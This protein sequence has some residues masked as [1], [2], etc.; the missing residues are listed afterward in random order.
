MQ[1]FAISCP[2]FFPPC[3]DFKLTGELEVLEKQGKYFKYVALVE[4]ILTA[5]ARIY[6]RT[7]SHW[8]LWRQLA[9]TANV[10]GVKL[11][12]EKKF[13]Q[14]MQMLKNATRLMDMETSGGNG[15]GGGG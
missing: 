13:S 6:E 10:F 14:A 7:E 1:F 3:S 4:A 11:I 5:R 15:E 8:R 9:V 12:D 2:T